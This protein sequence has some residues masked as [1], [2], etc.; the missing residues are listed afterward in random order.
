M[1]YV[2]ACYERD[3]TSRDYGDST[4]MLAVRK[5]E[6][7]AKTRMRELA[8]KVVRESH[9]DQM[10]PVV[11]DTTNTDE[12]RIHLVTELEADKEDYPAYEFFYEPIEDDC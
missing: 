6:Q 2:I 3:Q 8:E 1:L 9:E 7:E 12:T 4:E 5:T 11:V 10:G